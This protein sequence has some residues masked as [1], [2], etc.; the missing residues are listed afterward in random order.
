MM[1]ETD[2]LQSFHPERRLRTIA[3][4]S[5]QPDLDALDRV[6]DAGHYDVVFVGSIDHA[7]SQIRRT[8]PHCVIVCVDIDDDASFQILS[9][10]K[11]DDATSHIPVVTYV[12]VRSVTAQGDSSL[13]L[14]HDRFS[15][16]VVFSMN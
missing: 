5:R 6:L 15:A 8:L 16:P 12:S 14:D 13:E 10:L 2:R 7:Y 11:L 9:M 3:V 1:T 4:V